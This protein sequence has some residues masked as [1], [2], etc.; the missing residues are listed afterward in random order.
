MPQDRVQHFNQSCA[1][2]VRIRDFDGLVFTR[3]NSRQV[4]HLSMRVDVGDSHSNRLHVRHVELTLVFGSERSEE[5]QIIIW[6]D[7][8]QLATFVQK[9]DRSRLRFINRPASRADAAILTSRHWG[10]VGSGVLSISASSSSQMSS[11]TFAPPDPSRSMTEPTNDRSSRSATVIGCS[12]P[13]IHS[14]RLSRM[15]STAVLDF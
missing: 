9:H 14:L 4:V 12:Q 5:I 2:N 8:G 3:P 11:R 7:H 1:F 6:R 10:L 13:A 15:L